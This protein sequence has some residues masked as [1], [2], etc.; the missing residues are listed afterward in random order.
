[1]TSSCD[2]LLCLDEE[3]DLADAASAELDVVAL[4][5]DLPVA[6]I[7]MDL[8]LHGVNVGTGGE[9]QLLAQKKGK[10]LGEK[11]SP[12]HEI[13][14]ARPRLDECSSFPILPAALVVIECRGNGDRDMGSRR[15]RTQAQIEAKYV[16]VGRA[17]LQYFHEVAREPHIECSRLDARSYGSGV[18]EHHEVDVARIIELTCSHLAHGKDDIS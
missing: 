1:M 17:L 8:T 16:A 7:S 9:V 15:I 5:R 6:A 11:L 13:A 10:R 3:L 18:I 14:G 12:R 4:D 2:E